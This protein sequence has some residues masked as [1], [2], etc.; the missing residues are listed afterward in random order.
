MDLFLPTHPD[1]SRLNG[2]EN[3]IGS[4]RKRK[5]SRKTA[6]SS[7]PLSPRRNHHLT[8]RR[9]RKKKKLVSRPTPMQVDTPLALPSNNFANG[10]AYSFPA[11]LSPRPLTKLYK[12][13]PPPLSPRPPP[14]PLV[15]PRT[16]SPRRVKAPSPGTSL[17]NSPRDR[18]ITPSYL[19]TMGWHWED[20]HLM[21][22]N[23]LQK[24]FDEKQN[25]IQELTRM[26]TIISDEIRVAKFELL[27]L[28]TKRF[29]RRYNKKDII[30]SIFRFLTC[31][32]IVTCSQVCKT[33][34]ASCTPIVWKYRNWNM[35]DNN[36][37]TLLGRL[38]S[39]W[40]WNP[41]RTARGFN[42][43]LTHSPLQL[44]ADKVGKLLATL[45]DLLRRDTELRLPEL[46]RLSIQLHH[47]KLVLS[48]AGQNALH[49]SVV[50]LLQAAINVESLILTGDGKGMDL[51]WPVIQGIAKQA[52]EAQNG[53]TDSGLQRLSRLSVPVSMHNIH[54]V[55]DHIHG[56]L[57]KN[58]EWLHLMI[59]P[60]PFVDL[61]T[62]ANAIAQL[63][64]P[65]KMKHSL[66]IDGYVGVPHWCHISLIE[67]CL[68]RRFPNF[69]VTLSVNNYHPV[70]HL[71]Y[72][73]LIVEAKKDEPSEAV[74][75]KIRRSTTTARTSRR[76]GSYNSGG[77]S[78]FER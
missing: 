54:W 62:F 18:P 29:Q 43:H 20:R 14:P 76:L 22:E 24:K 36:D 77:T 41:L 57:L 23:R 7:S 64:I 47:S 49:D 12:P 69:H 52:E 42:F 16:S 5:R 37:W 48:P 15:I 26:S 73:S 2:K 19:Q 3:A 11:A 45:Q 10:P 60:Y 31:D 59:E 55:L 51:W 67:T 32:D 66:R 39:N 75:R 1:T 74:R 25:E 30:A 17:T 61:S 78:L 13:P 9:C 38:C 63:R 40:K 70:K 65:D 21:Q 58:L 34:A 44:Q 27:C 72:A 6:Y 33:W 46:R 53:G 4:R 28:K 35:R 56:D 71:F 68:A 8:P 50:K